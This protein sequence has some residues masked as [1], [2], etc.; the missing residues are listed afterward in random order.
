VK[1]ANRHEALVLLRQLG[2]PP[3]L[4]RHA[5][6]VGE[7]ADLLLS[8]LKRYGVQIDED[9]VRVGAA[10]H[11]AG[12]SLHHSE[13]LGPGSK[14]EPDGERLLLSHAAS[15]EVARVCR[16]HAQWDTVAETVEEL[17]IALSDKLWK[18]V[19]VTRLEELVIDHVAQSLQ[20][21][22]WDCFVELD[23]LFEDVAATADDR[24][25]R[26]RLDQP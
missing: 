18:G 8:G 21:D 17:V 22:R 20:K 13:L 2:A 16:S 24:L 15:P 7:A 9:Y 12:K 5:E 19:R 1:P 23:A 10:L 4:Y 11:D 26:S 25:A 6:L 14:H 3:R